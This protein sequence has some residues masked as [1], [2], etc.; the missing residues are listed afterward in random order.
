M[1]FIIPT[2]LALYA[3]YAKKVTIPGTLLAWLFGII[4]Y[5]WGNYPAF[6]ALA[7]VFILTIL[8]DKI[9]KTKKD[10][11]RNIKQMISN[12]LTATLCIILHYI[13]DNNVFYIMYY[14]VIGSSLADTLASSIGTLSRKKP[15]NIFTMKKIETGQ[16]GGVSLLGIFASLCGGMIVG[17]IYLE[18]DANFSNFL[19]ISFMG[20]CG[21][22]FD[23]IL[24]TIF[25]AKY[26]CIVCKKQVEEKKHCN[27]KTKLIKGF[28]M[29]DNNMV[30]LLSNI[31]VFVI[32]YILLY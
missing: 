1:N 29:I 31:F 22:I 3:G 13:T 7:T 25:E 12:V 28:P 19:L 26:Q 30:N 21:S 32:C 15:I 27:K 5:T 4:I 18:V 8:S 2:I 14:C 23:S 20:L 17:V 24:G 16:S 6:I 9:K 11:T 10:G